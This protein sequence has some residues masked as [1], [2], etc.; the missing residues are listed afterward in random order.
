MSICDSTYQEICKGNQFNFMRAY[1]LDFPD[2]IPVKIIF[3]RAEIFQGC[4]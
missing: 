2:Y 4:L 3:C 1:L